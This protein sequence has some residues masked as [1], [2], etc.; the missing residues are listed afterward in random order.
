MKGFDRSGWYRTISRTVAVLVATAVLA[1][2]P[3]SARAACTGDCNHNGTVSVDEILTMVNIA[4]GT[5]DIKTCEAGDPGMNGQITVDEILAAVNF[6]L[7]MCPAATGVCGDGTVDTANGEECDPGPGTCIG[8]SDAGKACTADSQCDQTSGICV[9]GVDAERACGSDSDCLNSSCIHCKTFGGNGCAANCTTESAVSITLVQGAASSDNTSLVSGSG[10]A[11][12]AD[13]D[14]NFAIGFP[15]GVTRQ[16]LIGKEKNGKIPVT[17]KSETNQTP[18]VEVLNGVACL[19]LRP[20]VYMTCG[21]TLW[22]KGGLPS[23]DCSFGYTAGDSVCSG[24]AKPCTRVYGPDNIGEGEV[25]CETAGLDGVDTLLSQ[26]STGLNDT[27]PV[28]PVL[29][30]LSG[31]GPAGSIVLFDTTELGFTLNKCVNASGDPAVYGKDGKFCTADDPYATPDPLTTGRNVLPQVLTTGIASATITNALTSGNTINTC[32]SGDNAGIGCSTDADC[33]GSPCLPRTSTG[34]PLSSCSALAGGA[35]GV[36]LADAFPSLR[37]PTVNDIVVIAPVVIARSTAAAAVCGDGVIQAPEQCDDGGICIGGSKAGTRCTSEAE[38]GA[39]EPGVCIGGTQAVAGAP[40]SG[41]KLLDGTLCNADAECGGGVCKRCKT[42]G[43]DG[44]A[45]NC[46]LEQDIHITLVSGQ[47]NVDQTLA[48]GS[49]S[50][51]DASGAGVFLGLPLGNSC[52]GGP[53]SGGSTTH[54]NPCATDADCSPGGKCTPST[55]VLTIGSRANG[56]ITG[57]IKANT[58]KFTPI[59]VPGITCACVRAVVYKSCGGTLFNAD[60]KLTTNCTDGYGGG[61]LAA[62]EGKAPCTE[63]F[64]PGN[65]AQGTIGCDGLPVTNLDW[66][67]DHLGGG[68]ACTMD[69]ATTVCPAQTCIDDPNSTTTTCGA[70][71]PVITFSGGTSPPG[72]AILLNTDAIGSAPPGHL[73]TALNSPDA[74][75]CAAKGTCVYGKDGLFCT[76]DDPIPPAAKQLVQGLA[77]TLPLVTGTATGEFIHANGVPT[78][79]NGGSNDKQPCTAIAQCPGG[80]CD[81]LEGPNSM[82]GHALSCDALESGNASGGALAGTFTAVNQP[83]TLDYV[84]TNVLVNQ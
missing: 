10:I 28:G 77:A 40:H 21:G 83:Q 15:A 58:L 45:R 16:W 20:I 60:G 54:G 43:G 75:D 7:T 73:C 37:A 76:D 65:S 67:Q 18:A 46:T 53:S 78:V 81:G 79:C 32:A 19:C 27:D 31:T 64:G 62:C 1:I 39:N 56:V 23:T 33:L 13:G 48:S 30:T 8:G 2:A 49:G 41:V 72:S 55:Q 51:L 66:T 24:G 25:G 12:H 59:L 42:F 84:V 4:L 6:A 63:V 9:D 26:S 70:F 3:H 5:G 47:I 80:I 11:V 74:A 50:L 17:M 22:E 52:V 29:T 61:G 38:C 14:F 34:T 71:D 44:C 36:T 35:S 82:S 57:V 69:N 68:T